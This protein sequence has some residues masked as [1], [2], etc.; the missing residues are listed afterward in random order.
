MP[1]DSRRLQG[2][3]DAFSYRILDKL[4]SIGDAAERTEKSSLVIDGSRK[5]NRKPSDARPLCKF[6]I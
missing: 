5:D 6:L 1:V 3:E 4:S 2:P